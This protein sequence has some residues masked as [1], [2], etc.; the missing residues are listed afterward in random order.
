MVRMPQR[1]L[2][3]RLLCRRRHMAGHFAGPGPVEVWL[4]ALAAHN[5]QDSDSSSNR[6]QHAPHIVIVVFFIII[7]CCGDPVSRVLTPRRPA[8][9]IMDEG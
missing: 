6:T 1:R 8:S 5:Q 2:L 4:A 3:L 7:I 9:I